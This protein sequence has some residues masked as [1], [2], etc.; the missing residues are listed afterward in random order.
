[1]KVYSSFSKT[2]TTESLALQGEKG[3]QIT[4]RYGVEVLS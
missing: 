4:C 1:M 3:G 2:F